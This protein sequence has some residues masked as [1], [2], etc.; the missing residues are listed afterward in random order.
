MTALHAAAGCASATLTDGDCG[1]GAM[2][3]GFSEFAGSRLGDW[4]KGGN[5]IRNMVLGGTASV[6]GGGTFANG[7]QTAAFGYLYNYCAHNGCFDRRF[8][9][10]DAVDQWRN[11]NGSAVTGVKASELNLTDATFTKNPSGTYQIHTSIRYDTGAIY[12]T[13]TGVLNA[14]GTMRI[15]PDVYDFDFK[16][17]IAVSDGWRLL[18]RDVLTGVGLS[19]NGWGG[20]PYR[21]EFTG[22]IKV[23]KSLTR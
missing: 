6:I 18:L 2:S 13:V 22:S 23:P 20:T 3:A 11:G 8:D 14:D 16:N 10:N 5:L 7:A 17:P 9:W 1:S 4:G 19:I 15:L 21:I 12:G